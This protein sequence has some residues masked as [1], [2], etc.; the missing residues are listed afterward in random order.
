M[1]NLISDIKTPCGKKL[2]DADT[3]RNPDPDRENSTPLN[4]AKEDTLLNIF[5]EEN[6]MTTEF[7]EIIYLTQILDKVKR[8]TL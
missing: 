3:L 4:Y 8:T 2:I 5:G 1:P 7:R 6:L